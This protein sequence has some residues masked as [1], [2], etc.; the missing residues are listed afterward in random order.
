M[1]FGGER[2]AGPPKGKGSPVKGY[3]QS[4]PTSEGIASER[5]TDQKSQ[6]REECES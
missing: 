3:A 6:R 2:L 5:A 1:F 4:L